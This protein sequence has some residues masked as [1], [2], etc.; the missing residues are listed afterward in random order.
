MIA[1]SSVRPPG[2]PAETGHDS[3]GSTFGAVHRARGDALR[4][5][6]AEAPA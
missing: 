5:R 4:E 1:A 2:A 3:D 6:V